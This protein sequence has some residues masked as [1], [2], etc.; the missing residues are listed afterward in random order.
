[1]HGTG[2][3]HEDE[4][5]GKAY[6]AHLMGRLVKDLLPYKG[7]LGLS[8]LLLLSASLLQI[9]QPYV[10]KLAIDRHIAKGVLSGLGLLA[11]LYLVALAFEHG[12]R[13]LQFYVTQSVGQKVMS[14]L[15]IRMFAHIQ[16]LPVRYFDRNPVGRIMTRLT[17]DVENINEMFTSG[18]VAVFGD[19]LMLLSIVTA[20]LLLDWKLSLVTFTVLPPLYVATEVFRKKARASY[21]LVRTKL[22]RLNAFLQ[23]SLSGLRIIQTFSKETDR[24]RRFEGIN[25]E[26]TE[27]G[28]QSIF[29]YAI[30]YPTVELLSVSAVALLI[31]YGGGE[32]VRGAL[33]LGT[34]VAFIEYVQR[35]FAPVKDLSEKYNIMQAAMASSERIFELLDTPEEPGWTTCGRPVEKFS[36]RIEFQGVWFAYHP[37]DYVLKDIS[38][39]IEPGEKVALVG[40]TGAGKTTLVGLLSRFYEPEKGSIRLDGRD[41]KELD[42]FSLR[43]QIGLVLQEPFLFATTIEANIRLREEVPRDRAYEA[44]KVVGA[45]RFIERLPL[46][47]GEEVLERGALLSMG[48]RQL[49]AL[50]RALAGDPD[51]VILDEATSSVDPETEYLLQKAVAKVLDGRT[52]LII[53]HRLSTIHHVDR[54]FVF[55]K[56]E[57]REEGTH[58]ELLQQDGIYA[59]LYRLQFDGHAMS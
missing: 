11:L 13:A 40:A 57:L 35:F 9:L 41:L 19:V 45:H 4:I 30:F 12:L 15:R 14:D 22:A 1:M 49:I 44:A 3:F 31:W 10:I 38:F 58:Q 51:I 54:I 23:E 5:L 52:A 27:A 46:R 2:S 17:S 32:I 21:R 33:T 18:L 34:L 25:R 56:G 16:H 7:S 36:G 24:L 6:D 42:L 47:Y 26:Y 48:E 8:A 50:A 59:R 37:G 53:A 39:T 55:H 29:Y 43:R 28:L 20:M